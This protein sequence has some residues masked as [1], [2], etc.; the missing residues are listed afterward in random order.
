MKYTNVNHNYIYAVEQIIASLFPVDVDT[1][2]DEIT[3]KLSIGKKYTTASCVLNGKYYGFAKE[4]N[5]RINESTA[6]AI[7][8]TSIYRAALQSGMKQPPWGA[9]S[10]VRPGKLMHPIMDVKRFVELYDVTEERAKLCYD[11]SL[12]TNKIIGQLQT[13]D[14]CLYVGIPFCPTRCAYCSFVSQSV[15]KNNKL[16]EPFL[17]ALYKEIDA[18]ASQV[19]RNQLKI[20]SI[21]FGGGTPTSLSAVQLDEL[22]TKLEKSFDLDSLRE[23]CVE[24]GRPDTITLEKIDVLKKHN[25]TRVSVNP[26]TMVDSV[27]DA[28]GRKHKASDIEK[29]IAI[30]KEVGNIDINMDLIAGLPTDTI[31]GFKCSIDKVLEMNPENVTIH[32]LSLKKGSALIQNKDVLPSPVDVG[33]MLEYAYEKLRENGY[34]PYYL[35]RQK[36]MSGGFENT[37][38]TKPNHENVYNICMMEELCGIL[39]AGGGG[40]SKLIKGAG[41][42]ERIVAPKYPLEYIQQIDKICNDKKKIGEFYVQA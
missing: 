19:S 33:I 15:E 22:C 1:Q 38:W 18:L 12:Y 16:I 39:A 14:I 9:L 10:G 34:E 26:Q 29:A 3:T 21:Y 13:K 24:A 4:E 40:S 17:D 41:K 23:Y 25:V 35:Y 7:I 20:V 6:Q 27:L 28:I 32:T 30:V 37:G 42:N 31:D 8:K 36:N 11:T 5:S 2:N